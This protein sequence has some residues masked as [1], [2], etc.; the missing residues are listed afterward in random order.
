[1]ESH[2]VRFRDVACTTAR[3]DHPWVSAGGSPG[4][5]LLRYYERETEG[6]LKRGVGEEGGTVNDVKRAR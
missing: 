3:R 1:M 4:D 5:R 2:V 6:A